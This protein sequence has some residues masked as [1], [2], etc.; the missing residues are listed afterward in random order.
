MSELK[1][2]P[3]CG[4]SDVKVDDSKPNEEGMCMCQ[5]CGLSAC[6]GVEWNRR[7]I[8]YCVEALLMCPSHLYGTQRHRNLERAVWVYYSHKK[9]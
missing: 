1:P 2:C 8:P 7:V 3:R 5:I 9:E 4:S 6:N